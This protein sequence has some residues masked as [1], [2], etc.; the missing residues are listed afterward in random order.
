MHFEILHSTLCSLPLLAPSV[1]LQEEVNSQS[2]EVLSDY[3][4]KFQKCMQS[5]GM[6]MG[7]VNMLTC[8]C[9]SGCE[10]SMCDR[11]QS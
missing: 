9:G 4:G 7:T 5:G 2:I 8:R 10:C 1:Q 6:C 11:K 3:V